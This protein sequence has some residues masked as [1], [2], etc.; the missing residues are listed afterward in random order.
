MEQR[1]KPAPE[2]RTNDKE[3]Y[4]IQNKEGYLLQGNEQR[5]KKDTCSR[6]RL[7]W[8]ALAPLSDRALLS[9]VVDGASVGEGDN[10]SG[11]DKSRG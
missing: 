10:K 4:L 7:S 8:G 5:T 11:L 3:G 9:R 6:A 1:R 2:Q